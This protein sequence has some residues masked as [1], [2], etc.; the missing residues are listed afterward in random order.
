M[1]EGCTGLTATPELPAMV[2]TNNCYAGM[3]GNCTSLNYVKM[4]ATDV[5]ATDSLDRWLENVAQS[6]TF[7]KHP[8][9]NS[10]PIGDNGIPE[11]WSVQNAE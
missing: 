9:M 4:L 6:G 3:F 8:D 2:S 11:G 5:S 10:L 1:F 7:I